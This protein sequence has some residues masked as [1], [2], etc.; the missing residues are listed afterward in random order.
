[1]VFVDITLQ[2]AEDFLPPGFLKE[3]IT[4]TGARHLLFATRKQLEILGQVKHWYV[5]A[6]VKV[7]SSKDT[8]EQLF[9]VQQMQGYKASTAGLRFHV[10]V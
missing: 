3:G 5:D 4:V 8:F 6:T 10:K 1:M 9:G 7:F 2:L